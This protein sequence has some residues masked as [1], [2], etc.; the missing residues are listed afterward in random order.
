MNEFRISSSE[1]SLKAHDK[2][3]WLYIGFNV[4]MTTVI[5]Q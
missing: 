3:V 4:T 1:Q 5:L 2:F